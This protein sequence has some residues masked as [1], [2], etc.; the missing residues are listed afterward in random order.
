MATASSGA[1]APVKSESNRTAEKKAAVGQAVKASTRPP[2]RNLAEHLF[3]EPYAYHFFQAVRILE[4]LEPARKPIGLFVPPRAEVV[5]FRAHRSL[6]FPPS[7]IY[8]LEPPTDELPAILTV[9]FMGL[10]GPSGALPRHYTELLLRH[11]K[12][13]RG[14]EQHAL[15]DWFDLFNH[16]LISHFYRA[17]EKY[18]FYIPYERGEY[19]RDEPDAFTRC[20][21]SLIGLGIGPLRNRLRV[22]VRLPAEE[23]L[24]PED[25]LAHVEDLALLHYCGF[26][27]HR[28]RC[29]VA[30]EAL[31]GDYFELLVRVKQFHGQWLPLEPANQSRVGLGEGNSDLGVNVVA[32]SRVWD[33][34]NKFRI[35]LGPLRYATFT[36]FLPDR[37]PVPERKTFFKLAHLVR[38][39]VGPDLDF[40]V[41]LIL[42]AQDVPPCRLAPTA[43]FTPRLGWNTWV[44]SLPFECDAEEAVFEG[45]DVRWVHN[46]TVSE[47]ASGGR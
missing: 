22:S 3:C 39:Y 5:R 1:T 24:R 21:F 41:Q 29:A 17:W 25:V 20:L 15:R 33:V 23:E 2:P 19:R 44:S 35:Q 10:T 34:Q 18:R 8:D 43:S 30:L 9:A 11:D 36:E 45:E 13:A 42:R 31:L 46:G 32:G 26:L 4:R 47:P 27:A 14:P 28:P 12:E 40:D 6:S 38:L 16:R 7:S 37:S